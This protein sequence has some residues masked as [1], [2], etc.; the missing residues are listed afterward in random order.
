[1]DR[2]EKHPLIKSATR[3]NFRPNKEDKRQ[4]LV[5]IQGEPITEIS[6]GIFGTFHLRPYYPEPLRCTKCQCFDHHISMCRA[7]P[8]CA[9]CSETHATEVCLAKIKNGEKRELNTSSFLQKF[10]RLSQ[11]AN[12]ESSKGNFTRGNPSTSQPSIKP[13]LNK[14]SPPF[15]PDTHNR[16]PPIPIPSIP[17]TNCGH[18]NE[19]P[20]EIGSSA[21]VIQMSLE[22][23]GR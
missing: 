10:H 14:A 5:T 2:L 19:L 20:K 4:V 8:R 1:M 23:L 22:L 13:P 15:I 17:C 6:L 3:L 9:I 7:Q 12:R 11:R 18:Q 21:S 16:L